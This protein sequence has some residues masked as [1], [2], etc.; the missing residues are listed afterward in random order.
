M[1]LSTNCLYYNAYLTA[2]KMATELQAPVDPQWRIKA[3]RIRDAI[4]SRLWDDTQGCY[5]FLVGPLG[6][7][8]HQ[9]GLGSAYA[10]LFGIADPQR[11]ELVFAAQHVTPAGLPC[12]WPNLPR[13]E[14]PDGMS[15]GRHMG[16]VWPQIQ[17]F[18]AEAAA[19]AGKADLFGHEFLKLA[20][21]A[22][23]D[24]HFAEIYHPLTGLPYGGLQENLGQGIVLWEAT[25]RQTW[26]ATAYLRMVLLGLCGLRFDTEGVRFQP[27]VPD[28]IASVDLRNLAYGKMNL[29]VTIRGTGTKIKQC[30]ISGKE[31]RDG[32]VSATDEGHKAVTITMA[33]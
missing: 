20:S 14:R 27:C 3:E 21:H 1:A 24:N 30:L 17:G 29:D 32:F 6:D 9:E 8:D 4:N 10:L 18:W 11:A 16:T 7:C 26:A 12:G 23:R 33:P 28:G 15:F 19:R 31:S 25:S 13:Y 2:E 5:R 22:A